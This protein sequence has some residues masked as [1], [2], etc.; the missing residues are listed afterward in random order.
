VTQHLQ[1]SPPAADP[2]IVRDTT[3][4]S[5]W[6]LLTSVCIVAAQVLV[7]VAFAY[8]LIGRADLPGFLPNSSQAGTHDQAN[9]VPMAV[10]TF[11]CAGALL[12]A[13]S[14]AQSHRSWLRT[15]RWHRKH[16]RI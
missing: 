8:L 7:V 15:R 4:T 3:A 13:G 2:T 11:A 1:D 14:Y 16:G 12:Y 6:R 10:V 5:S 9:D